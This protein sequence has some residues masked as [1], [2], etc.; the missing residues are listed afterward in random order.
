MK[1]IIP[2]VCLIT[3]SFASADLSP[4][5]AEY[6]N[7]RQAE[8]DQI[9]DSRRIVLEPLAKALAQGLQGDKDTIDVTFVCTHNSRRSHMSQLWMKAAAESLRL[10]LTTWSGGTESTAM[11]PRAVA[12]LRRAGF[13]ITQT[14]KNNNPIYHC[15]LY[16]SPSPR[17]GLLSRMPSSA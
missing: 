2:F 13:D 4:K 14:T 15:L 16:T 5:L 9:D 17:D 12:S 7:Q 1:F 3:S 8:F 10:P 11:N 6:L